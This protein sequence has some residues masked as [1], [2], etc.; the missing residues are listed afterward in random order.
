MALIPNAPAH[1][2]F[3]FKFFVALCAIECWMLLVLVFLQ[4]FVAILEFY[5]CAFVSGQSEEEWNMI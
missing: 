5:L 1:V 4:Q 3:E 2:G